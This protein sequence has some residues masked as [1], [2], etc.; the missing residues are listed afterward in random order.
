MN[1]NNVWLQKTLHVAQTTF[2]I[3][4]C[5]FRSLTDVNC[6][7]VENKCEGSSEI[8]LLYSTEEKNILR[9]SAMD[10]WGWVNTDRISIFGWTIPLNVQAFAC[11]GF[12]QA[13]RVNLKRWV[14]SRGSSCGQAIT[15]ADVEAWKA[16]RSNADHHF[17]IRFRNEYLSLWRCRN[18]QSIDFT[19]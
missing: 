7:C 18:S 6:H 13:S 8:L 4:F 5:H 2:L 19:H 1:N 14:S 16:I 10:E 9:K 15:S 11:S 3:F 17:T 12:F